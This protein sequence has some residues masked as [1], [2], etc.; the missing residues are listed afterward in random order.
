MADNYIAKF[1]PNSHFFTDPN[2]LSQVSG[3]AFGPAG[4][5]EFWLTTRF[6]VS[7]AKA[8]AICKGVVLVQP[9]TGSTDLVNLILRPY[10]QPITGFNIKYFIYRGLK[11]SDFF[12]T[13]KVLPAATGSSDFITKVNNSFA[14]FYNS[15]SP[16]QPLP[17]FLAKYIGF[18][19]AIQDDALPLSDFFFKESEYVQSGQE[20]IEQGEFAFELPLIHK[21]ASLGSFANGECGIDIVLNYGDYKLPSPNDEF[22]FDLAYA[23]ASKVK[24]ELLAGMSNYEKKL[25][26]EQIFQF[27]DAAAYFGFHA[28]DGGAVGVNSGSMVEKKGEAIYT[29]VVSK[30]FTKNRLYL[31]IQSDRTRSYN[32]YG[33]YTLPDSVNDLNIGIGAAA[34]V[35]KAYGVDGWPLYIDDAPRGHNESKNSLYFQLSSDS[36]SNVNRMLYGQVAQIVNAQHNN[37]CGADDLQLPTD[38]DGIPSEWTKIIEISNPATGP[39]G[40]KLNIAS[41]NILLYQGRI[42]A[43]EAGEEVD[44]NSETVKIYDIPNFFDDVFDLMNA[45]PLL[46][47]TENTDFSIL[48]SQK[49][50]IINHYYDKSQKGISAVQTTI[51]NDIIDTDDEVNPALKRVTYITESVDTLNTAI[52]LSGP[53]AND[54]NSRP[55][56]SGGV[57]AN[58]TY[59]LPEPFY[60]T[61]SPF[62]DSTTTITG[63]SLK[64]TDNSIPNKIIL[65][66]TKAENDLLK[67]LISTNNL[68]NPRMFLIDLFEDGNELISSEG[69]LYQKYRMSIVA[70]V[71]S[72]K[73]KLFMPEEDIMMYAIDR[74]Y[75]Y[76]KEYS[77]Y[78]PELIMP[79]DSYSPIKM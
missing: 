10:E 47:V 38:P 9:Q 33:N 30:F 32:F 58:K 55:S 72:G 60:Y 5:D 22:L 53:L 64:A 39:N 42:Y 16:G 6:S 61:L 31:Y 13:N 44:E 26:R 70:E 66:L 14:S 75:Y 69:I 51:I 48:S 77:K 45:E 74:H 52:S 57:V 76:T 19:P 41:F 29:D 2:A 24:I 37:F 63:L 18:D 4:A 49:V 43:Y 3:Q 36:D 62:T 35:E 7:G 12:I 11:K 46:K 28:M 23:R 79:G 59:A 67:G 71:S 15:V 1:K 34:L 25:K 54:T 20:F 56:V 17:D 27:L 65:G 73:L 21:G 50:K 8:F 68:N 78:V 40:A